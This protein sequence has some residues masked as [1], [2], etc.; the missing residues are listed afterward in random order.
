MRAGGAT[1]DAERRR[2]EHRT[3]TAGAHHGSPSAYAES[4][5]SRTRRGR[6]P[7]GADPT[8]PSIAHRGV[9]LVAHADAGVPFD[10]RSVADDRLLRERLVPSSSERSG[11]VLSTAT[12]AS[13]R[14]TSRR[15]RSSVSAAGATT[16]PP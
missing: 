8:P 4:R 16:A 12:P 14:D 10:R 15:R 6:R 11:N 2:S 9:Q 3:A 5:M 1:G 13:Q 7:L